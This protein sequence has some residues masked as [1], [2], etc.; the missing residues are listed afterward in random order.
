MA[1]INSK[2][3]VCKTL[4]GFEKSLG[5][6]PPQVSVLAYHSI[7]N[8]KSIVDIDLKTFQKQ[9][10]FLK[11]NFQFV[12]IDEVFEYVE[13]KREFV[14]PVVAITFDDG[15]KTV[16]E[17][18]FPILEKNNIPAS[19]F[20][21]SDPKHADRNSLENNNPFMTVAQIKKLHSKGWA[22]G[23]HSATHPEFAD[24]NLDFKREIFNAKKT[25]ESSLAVKMNFYVYPKGVYSEKIIDQVKKA[26][27]KGAFSF[28]AG[29]VSKSSNHFAIPR[30]PVDW[31]HSQEQFEAFFTNWGLKYLQTKK[32]TEGRYL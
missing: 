24:P 20:V 13:G 22:V 25:L 15:Y 32:I 16:F 18:A 29:D 3:L 6:V 27:F 7:S 11:K 2:N 5:F 26:K 12:N 21:L 28:Q 14:H 1:K 4:T 31:T 30:I 8:N 10:D 17:N 9:I 23:C 19:I